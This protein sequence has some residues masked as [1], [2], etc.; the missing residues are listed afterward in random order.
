[1]KVIARLFLMSLICLA[2]IILTI[3]GCGGSA[4][5]GT[6]AGAPIDPSGNWSLTFSDSS[7]R[8]LLMSALFSQTGSIVS[9][10]NILAVGN[11]APFSCTPFSASFANGQVLN[12][13][14]FSGDINTPFGNIHFDSTLNLAGSHAQGTYTLTGNCWNVASTGTFSADEIPSISGTWTGTVNC[15]QNCPTGSTTGTISMTLTQNDATGVVAGNYSITGLPNISSGP[16]STG[17]SDFLSGASW[18]DSLTDAIGNTFVIA[19]GPFQQLNTSGLGLDRSFHGLIFETHDID[20]QK[21]TVATYSVTM[22][23]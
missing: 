10:S 16:V 2:A 8:T 9:A 17:T 4:S 11:P 20:P 23:H 13:D 12:V 6:K 15:T 1:M 5:S 21:T 19:G 14:Q 22:T 18:Q 7:N 3:T